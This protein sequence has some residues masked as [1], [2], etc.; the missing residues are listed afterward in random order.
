MLESRNSGDGPAEDQRM[1]VMR[2]LIGVDG[3]EVGGVTHHVELSG[4]AIAAVH[5]SGDA[6]DVERLAA[7][8]TLDQADC[9]GDQLACLEAATDAQHCLQA[10][11][12]L[13]Y[14]IGEL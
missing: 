13:R 8:V 7:I 9:L 6:G 14:H 11:R 5:V 3:F 12:D 1:D 2:A 4:Y 10:E